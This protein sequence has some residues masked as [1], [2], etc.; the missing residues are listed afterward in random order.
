MVERRKPACLLA[1]FLSLGRKGYSKEDA[2]TEVTWSVGSVSASW[3]I[4]H[5][6][7]EIS[8]DV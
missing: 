6:G 3:G 5:V 4:G 8:I 1:C 2:R 7:V